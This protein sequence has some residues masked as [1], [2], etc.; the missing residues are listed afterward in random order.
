MKKKIQE[1]TGNICIMSNVV[2]MLGTV[3]LCKEDA[4]PLFGTHV[5]QLMNKVK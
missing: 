3:Y 5:Q 4:F 1:I 2:P